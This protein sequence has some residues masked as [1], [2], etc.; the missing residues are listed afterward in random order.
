MENKDLRITKIGGSNFIIVPSEFCKVYNLTNY[1]Y[2]IEVSSD[3]KTITY[4]RMRKDE[5]LNLSI[6]K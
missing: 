4:R 5:Q 2:Y 3:G 1:V 6:K